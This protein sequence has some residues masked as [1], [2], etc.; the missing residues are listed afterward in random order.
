MTQKVEILNNMRK[1]LFKA[2]AMQCKGLLSI[3]L[4]IFSNNPVTT[5]FCQFIKRV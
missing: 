2:K 4:Q 1:I 5:F 3:L